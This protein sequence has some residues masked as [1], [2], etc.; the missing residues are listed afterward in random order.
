MVFFGLL[1]NF[2]F[3]LVVLVDI[4]VIECNTVGE[5]LWSEFHLGSVRFYVA[6]TVLK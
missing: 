5:H 4:P 3:P 1:F 2:I 6:A